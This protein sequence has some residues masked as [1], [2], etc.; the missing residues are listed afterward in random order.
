MK[1]KAK[2]RELL[3]QIEHLKAG[4]PFWGYRR[5]W[6][7]LKY[8]QGLTV[9][10]K[11]IYRLMQENGLLVLPNTRL[12]AVRA[13]H[14]ERGKPRAIRPNQYWGIDMTK[15][16]TKSF[17]WVYLIIVLDWF[18]K[19][20]IGYSLKTHSRTDDW[21]EALNNAINNQFPQGILSREKD[22]QLFLISDNGSQPTSRKF[23][24]TCSLLG[25]KQI[26][27][28]Y[29]N[30]KG[31]ADTERVIRTIKEDLIWLREWNLPFEIEEELKTW[32]KNYNEDFPHSSLGY[33]TP[34]QF[35]KEQLLLTTKI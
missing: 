4:H 24:E 26:F 13:N 19:K 7:Y 5:I 30:P 1:I 21:L 6:A 22:K 35:E 2:N 18:S 9:N 20:I 14:P 27:T 11:R 8:R 12:K 28:C 15:V 16:M 31:N 3:T 23:M 17:G 32:I 34:S 29:N 33:K 25:I 10:K